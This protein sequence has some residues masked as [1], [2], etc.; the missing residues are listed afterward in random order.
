MEQVKRYT[1]IMKGRQGDYMAESPTGE[2]ARYADVEAVE[3]LVTELTE[4]LADET[5]VATRNRDLYYELEH[6]HHRTL[7][8][9]GELEHALA[10][11]KA[12]LANAQGALVDAGTVPTENLAA[13]IR[14]LTQQLAAKEARVLELELCG[15]DHSTAYWEARC[16]TLQAELAKLKALEFDVKGMPGSKLSLGDVCGYINA[17]ERAEKELAR[18][19]EALET[20]IRKAAIGSMNHA[21]A[22]DICDAIGGI[23]QAALAAADQPVVEGVVEAS[24][25]SCDCSFVEFYT[26]AHGIDLRLQSDKLDVEINEG[27]RL[28]VVA[29][30]ER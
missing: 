23:A 29:Y 22:H 5:E 4:E 16:N 18:V 2:W 1:Q 13:G 7:E 6:K 28:R 21:D 14:A 15:H 27:D 19:R 12:D 25:S 30:K 9:V 11:M 3:A 10:A 24:C 20:I 8:Q 17:R 26:G